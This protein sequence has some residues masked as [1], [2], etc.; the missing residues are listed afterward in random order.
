MNC[1][2]DLHILACGICNQ[3]VRHSDEILIMLVVLVSVVDK[4]TLKVVK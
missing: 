4:S 2:P 3:P 1:D